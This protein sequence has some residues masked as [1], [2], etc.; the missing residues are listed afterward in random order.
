MALAKMRRVIASGRFD[1]FGRL[2]NLLL[3]NSFGLGRFI[4]RLAGEITNVLFGLFGGVADVLL[5]AFGC[6]R[7]AARRRRAGRGIIRPR[8]IT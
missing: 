6:E 5:Q 3:A 7:R 1:G 4:F 2:S 8:S